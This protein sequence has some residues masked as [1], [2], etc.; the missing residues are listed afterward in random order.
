MESKLHGVPNR[1]AQRVRDAKPDER[2]PSRE[3]KELLA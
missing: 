1:R 3:S 2:T